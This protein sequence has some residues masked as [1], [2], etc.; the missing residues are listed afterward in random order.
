VTRIDAALLDLLTNGATG[1]ALP[2]QTNVFNTS[3]PTKASVTYPFVEFHEAGTTYVTCGDGG[4]VIDGVDAE[5]LVQ[6]F[7][8]TDDYGQVEPAM[9]AVE[10][11]LL[12]WAPGV[13][14][15]GVRLTLM[16]MMSAG[17][18]KE[19]LDRAG[20]RYVRAWQRCKIFAELV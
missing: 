1:A 10:T 4:V 3:V 20:T 6:A 9:D 2:V 11:D 17:H 8:D 18:E 14:V 5:Y 13:V 12:T 15:G 19:P 7:S 16:E